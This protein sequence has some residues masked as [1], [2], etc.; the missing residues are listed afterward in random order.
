[1][2]ANLIS[3]FDDQVFSFLRR[4]SDDQVKVLA[5]TIWIGE[6]VSHHS[7]LSN[8]KNIWEKMYILEDGKLLLTN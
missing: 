6:W 3:V 7:L 2:H 4:V 1:M 8:Y 5:F